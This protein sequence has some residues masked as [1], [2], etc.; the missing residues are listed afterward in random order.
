MLARALAYEDRQDEIPH[1]R[2]QTLELHP[3]RFLSWFVRREF[4]YGAKKHA[5]DRQAAKEIRR[6]NYDLFH[7]WSG[8]CVRTLREA[9]RRG[10]PSLI[11]IPTWHR[12]KGKFKPERLT[13]SE[14]E[15]AEAR[16]LSGLRNRLLVSRQQALEEYALAEPFMTR[17][18]HGCANLAAA[19]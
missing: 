9:K 3:V 15:R 16:G 5:L 10:I 8:E 6:G 17:C 14:R 18:A 13:Q 7:G 1:D 12:H 2:I 19:A 11:E 4:Y